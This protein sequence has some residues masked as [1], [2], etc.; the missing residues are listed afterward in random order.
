MGYFTLRNV[1]IM[2]VNYFTI[3]Y[4]ALR[5]QLDYMVNFKSIPFY[6]ASMNYKKLFIHLMAYVSKKFHN[7]VYKMYGTITCEKMKNHKKAGKIKIKT[8]YIPSH[9]SIR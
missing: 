4:T 6:S 8:S 2:Y 1:G 9:P 3:Q 7:R 5:F